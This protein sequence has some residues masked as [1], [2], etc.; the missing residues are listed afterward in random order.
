MRLHAG[1]TG[2]Q[3]GGVDGFIRYIINI[4]IGHFCDRLFR[5][6]L[7]TK[8]PDELEGFSKENPHP[9]KAFLKAEGYR[10]GFDEDGKGGWGNQFQGDPAGVDHIEARRVLGKAAEMIG[11]K[12]EAERTPL[13]GRGSAK[14]KTPPRG[15]G[16]DVCPHNGPRKSLCDVGLATPAIQLDD[17]NQLGELGR[18]V[19]HRLIFSAQAASRAEQ[20][21]DIAES[22]IRRVVQDGNEPFTREEC[23]KLFL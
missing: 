6:D 11:A 22:F 3:F 18:D 8:N 15:R 13:S 17:G 1:L 23:R 7:R 12:V 2:G 10:W 4:I 20:R 5:R 16:Y 14:Q 21:A 9:V 19:C